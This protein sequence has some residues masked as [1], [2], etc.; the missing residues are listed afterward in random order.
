MRIKIKDAHFS[1]GGVII[2]PIFTIELP[3]YSLFATI[4]LVFAVI[5]I[6]FRIDKMDS[7]FKEYLVC[8][9]I[10]TITALIGSRIVFVLAM[11]PQIGITANAILYYILNGGIV[12]YGGLLGVLFGIYLYSK[13]CKKSAKKILDLT[14][15][16]MPMFH[17]F[18]RIG[19]LFAG[20]CYGIPWAWG[21]VMQD[22]P[23]VIRFPVQFVESIC[24]LII[25][26]VMIFRE[27]KKKT[28]EGNIYI[29]LISYGICRY[30]LE[31]FRGDA[32]RGIWPVGMSTSQI[33]SALIIIVCVLSI[34]KNHYK[35][36]KVRE[37]KNEEDA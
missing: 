29:Y 9:I 17:F 19:C 22:T 31:Y 10:C 23:D 30:I 34:I 1:F 33:I 36:K 26:L 27:K 3:A 7:S 18:A 14:A 28:S 35:D 25:S 21:V 37:E 5:F 24:C 15:P 2:L 4:G 11:L 12:F 16:A 20:C 6:Y 8:L 32:V 13:I